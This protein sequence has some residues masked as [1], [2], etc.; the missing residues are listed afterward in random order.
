MTAEWDEYS[1]AVK[2]HIIESGKKYKFN[3]NLELANLLPWEW[4]LGDAT[5][6]LFEVLRW[7]S[8][9]IINKFS[10]PREIMMENLLKAGHCIQI[11]YTKLAQ[12]QIEKPAEKIEIIAQEYAQ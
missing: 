4:A 6:Y 12:I 1:K 9:G 7:I 11:A 10:H 3:D 2:A 8:E 5:K